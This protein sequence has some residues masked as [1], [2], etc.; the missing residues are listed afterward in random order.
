MLV[1]AVLFVALNAIL[2]S[3]PRR[4]H[5]PRADAVVVLSGDHGERLP[6]ALRLI[7]EGVSTI[8]VLDGTPDSAEGLALCRERRVFELFEVVCLHPNPDSTRAEARAAGQLA[9]DRD[10]KSLIVVTTAYHVARS[11]LL[12]SR[13]FDGQL[14][15]IGADPPYGWRRSFEAV[16]REWL[17]LGHAMTVGRGC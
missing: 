6:I 9:A 10:W 8:L 15:V 4:S 1:V 14:A 7:R 16:A 12:F 3:W 5:P 17:A 13:C 11:T 2:F